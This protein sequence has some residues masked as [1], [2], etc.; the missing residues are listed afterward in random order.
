[1]GSGSYGAVWRAKNKQTGKIVAIK[2]IDIRE[3]GDF[4]SVVKEIR[5]LADVD[6]PNVVKYYESYLID[7]R[8]LWVR[9]FSA[10]FP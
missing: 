9:L 2:I 4:D 1:M 6:H 7:H 3:N 8:F 10:S 5:F